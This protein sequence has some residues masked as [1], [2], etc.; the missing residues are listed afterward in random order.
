[1]KLSMIQRMGSEYTYILSLCQLV[2]MLNYH[3]LVILEE[4]ISMD[5]LPP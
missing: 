3:K 2:F 4:E 1:M 5:K